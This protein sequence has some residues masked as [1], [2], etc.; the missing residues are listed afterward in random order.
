[1][2]QF[3]VPRRGAFHTPIFWL[4]LAI[5]LERLLAMWILGVDYNLANDD[6]GYIGSGIHFVDTGMVS[7]YTPYPSAMIMPGMTWLLGGMTWLFG[8][9]TLYWLSAKLLW[10]AMGTCTAF[11]VYKTVRLLLP[12]WCALGAAAWFLA[13]N[14]AWMDNVLLTETPYFLCFSLTV[15]LTFRMERSN[16][17]PV[18]LGYCA[19]YLAG[20][21]L[22]PTLVVM[23]VFSLGYLFLRGVDRQLLLRRMLFGILILL[24][25][26]AP[27][28]ARNYHHFGIFVPLTYGS[29]N[30]MLLGTYQGF[31]YPEDEELDYDTN[32]EQ[33]FREEYA[34]LLEADGSI[35]DSVLGQYLTLQKDGVKARY[36][37]QAW[38]EQ[39]PGSMLLSYLVIKPA[40]MVVKTFY[41]QE[42]FG[43]PELLLDG[44]RVV[45][46]LL[47]CLGVFW[48]WKEKRLRWE[49]GFLS[50]VYWA[51]IYMIAMTFSFSRYGETLMGL[52]YVLAAA[53][54]YFLWEQWDRRSKQQKL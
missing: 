9:E 20:V 1:M 24:L 43:V 32:V 13:P 54:M 18:F 50:V 5:F 8:T 3:S 46:F 26:L 23:P 44:L 30:P 29:G 34:P 31:G 22:R 47:C 2:N 27:W 48:A 19:A 11:V 25:T 51:Y 36:R 41:W 17:R 28:T 52:R 7:I 4:L 49:L 6:M 14:L 15:Y 40:A 16:S 35:P 53:G 38:W 39:S 45:N 10:C 42:L 12:N 21:L 37:M 33:V